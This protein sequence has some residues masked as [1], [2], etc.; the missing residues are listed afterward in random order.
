MPLVTPTALV[1][2]SPHSSWELAVAIIGYFLLLGG[3]SATTSV[4]FGRRRPRY[5]KGASEQMRW[6][7][8]PGA[9][10]VV[11]AIVGWLS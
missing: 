3:L 9:I 2:R 6:L 5:R 10:L 4:Y 8:I 7:A 1:V 11:A